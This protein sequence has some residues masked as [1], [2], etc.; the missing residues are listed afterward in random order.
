V[1]FSAL[2]VI[3]TAVM[4]KQVL[5]LRKEAQR[6]RLARDGERVVGQ[7]L[8]ELRANGASIF[9][10]VPG[11]DFNLDHVVISD[12]GIF[13]VETKTH[14]K[15]APDAKVSF[16]GEQLLVAGRRLDRDP[17]QQVRAQIKWIRN[18]LRESTGKDLPVRGAIVF[19]NWWV[20]PAPDSIRKGI[21]VLEP[22]ALLVYIQNEPTRLVESD[23]KLA[24][25][26][27]SQYIRSKA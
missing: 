19:P 26:H 17:I 11:D 18:I 21:W 14:S 5:R 3:A 25:F 12:R 13:V 22:K 27:L 7:F 2:A 4:I 23:V 24:T 10:D 15:P 16:A 20:D 1:L 8:E 9:H 6:I